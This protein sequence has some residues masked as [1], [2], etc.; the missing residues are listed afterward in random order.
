MHLKELPPILEQYQTNFK[1]KNL[2][3]II[4][5]G[6]LTIV[7][8]G[9]LCYGLN[10]LFGLF[11]PYNFWTARQDIHSGKIRI[12]EVGEMPLNFDKKQKLAEFYGF[13]FS[14]FGCSITSGII[15]GTEY[16][17]NAIIE[18]LESK[19]GKGW[20]AKFQTQLDSID[21]ASLTDETI[22]KV[23]NLVGEQKIVKDQ[24]NLIDS[25]SKGQR[26]ISLIPFLK[27]TTKNIYLIKVAE[28]NGANLVNYF[29]FLVDANSMTIVNADGKLEGQ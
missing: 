2:K 19:Y 10:S 25:L 26:H 7:L 4:K 14:L 21:H 22:D 13:Y 5:Y 16:Y 1:I 8:L 24:I 15:N 17:N 28:D 6:L 3:R 12:V 9:G 20:W 23:L 29:N 11:T 18:H 27:D